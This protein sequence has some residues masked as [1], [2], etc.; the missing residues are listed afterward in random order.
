MW[1]I[2]EHIYP[3]ALGWCVD[4]LN[5]LIPQPL[6]TEGWAQDQYTQEAILLVPVCNVLCGLPLCWKLGENEHTPQYTS[7]RV[8]GRYHRNALHPSADL[9]HGHVLCMPEA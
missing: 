3:F 8:P 6:H 1:G 4:G 9:L 5:G 7:P 2:C